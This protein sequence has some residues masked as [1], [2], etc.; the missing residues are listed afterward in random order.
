MEERVNQMTSVPNC[1]QCNR[2]H[3][4]FQKCVVA[5]EPTRTEAVK[6]SPKA[7]RGGFGFPRLKSTF[8]F[9]TRTP[10]GRTQAN[11]TFSNEVP[12]EKV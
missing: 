1:K 6:D 9:E 3:W 8:G 7:R 12:N 11:P 2:Q 5:N 10:F 4:Q